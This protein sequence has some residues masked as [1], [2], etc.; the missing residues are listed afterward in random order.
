MHDLGKMLVVFLPDQFG[1]VCHSLRVCAFLMLL[2]WTS[3]R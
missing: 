2:N 1:Q 3:H